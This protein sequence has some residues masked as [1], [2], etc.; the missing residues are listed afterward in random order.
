MIIFPEVHATPDTPTVKFREARDKTELDI[1]LPKIL[2]TNGWGCGTY[3]HVQFMNHEKTKLL[4][5]ALYVVS[6]EIESLYT[7]ET[8]PYQP[9]T[10]T[11]ISRKAE[12]VG[13]WQ[14]F[15]TQEDPEA[16]EA[17]VDVPVIKWNP[18]K[19]VHQLKSG[20]KIIYANADKK[21]V[22]KKRRSYLGLAQV[23][24]G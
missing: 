10:K 7:N 22:E 1:E 9:V 6:E 15:G 5:Q 13:N 24:G 16:E 12:I 14:Y 21:L 11:L 20:E 3:F 4:S 17:T 23:A 8:N 2:H 18:G 19:K